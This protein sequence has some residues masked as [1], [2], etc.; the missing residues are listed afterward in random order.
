MY[1]CHATG[2]KLAL[3]QEK[4]S[5][6]VSMSEKREIFRVKKFVSSSSKNLQTKKA[7]SQKQVR[8]AYEAKNLHIAHKKIE[9]YTYLI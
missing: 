9:K 8:H 7:R 2:R 6:G 3:S 4:E 1:T 5:F